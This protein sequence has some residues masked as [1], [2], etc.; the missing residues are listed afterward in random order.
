MMAALRVPVL[1]ANWVGFDRERIPSLR[2]LALLESL[3]AFLV[4][5]AVQDAAR[6]AHNARSTERAIVIRQLSY[7]LPSS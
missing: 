2:S 7:G 3:H 6:K 5:L 1:V 4:A